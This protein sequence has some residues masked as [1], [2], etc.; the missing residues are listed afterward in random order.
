MA[1]SVSGGGVSYPD[2]YTDAVIAAMPN[3]SVG[4]IYDDFAFDECHLELLQSM[5]RRMDE[6]GGK[7]VFLV[8]Y[9]FELAAMGPGGL[10]PFLAAATPA[11]GGR[12]IQA[13]LSNFHS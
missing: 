4:V 12:A 8:V 11:M 3:S 1:F 5:S 2:N 10:K 13:L 7:D 9:A 6:L